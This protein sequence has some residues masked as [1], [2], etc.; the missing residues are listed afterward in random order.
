MNES[1]TCLICSDPIELN[2]STSCTHC[3]IE[4]CAQCLVEYSVNEVRRKKE[5][6]L[7]P[8]CRRPFTIKI[9]GKEI[10]LNKECKPI[11]ITCPFT[12]KSIET[13]KE[14]LSPYF[15]N[16]FLPIVY[17]IS[18]NNLIKKIKEN[19]ENPNDP[20]GHFIPTYSNTNI[21]FHIDS[22]GLRIEENDSDSDEIDITLTYGFSYQDTMT[23]KT[24]IGPT[25]TDLVEFKIVFRRA[26]EHL[27]G[28][29]NSTKKFSF[30]QSNFTPKLSTI[31]CTICEK[32]FIN[33]RLAIVHQ[34]TA[35]HKQALAKY[36][37]DHGIE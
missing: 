32:D 36:K 27:I 9:G 17:T 7:C 20:N 22:I 30:I 6:I 5:K 18:A 13:N 25:S 26:I 3:T 33:K 2:A 16:N 14:E 31:R 8:H 10:K 23:Y 29:N 4:I 35:I 24:E 21:E 34:K 28:Y 19:Y 37:S 15:Y 1:K 11:I 12:G